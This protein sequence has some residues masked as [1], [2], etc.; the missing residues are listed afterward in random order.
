MVFNW[1]DADEKLLLMRILA[2][3]GMKAPDFNEV[4]AG[5]PEGVTV[6]ACKHRMRKIKKEIE[7]M[8]V[9]TSSASGGGAALGST[10]AKSGGGK[11]VKGTP[12]NSKRKIGKKAATESEESPSCDQDDD[13]ESP[14][15]KVKTLAV[16]QEVNEDEDDDD[17]DRL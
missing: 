10:P 1:T 9:G 3:T 12:A 13:V 15:K 6:E 17:D 8:E 2:Q 16:K 11:K 14:T 5:M 7:A 4:V